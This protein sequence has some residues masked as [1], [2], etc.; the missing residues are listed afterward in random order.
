MMENAKPAFPSFPPRGG[1][2][3][4][5]IRI[6]INPFGSIE[7]MGDGRPSLTIESDQRVMTKVP[8]LYPPW[9]FTRCS[10]TGP[11]IPALDKTFDLI[12][13]HPSRGWGFVVQ[14][15]RGLRKLDRSRLEAQAR[16]CNGLQNCHF[17]VMLASFSPS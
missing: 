11:V 14:G 4:F 2:W 8:A 5:A 3:M 17:R 15:L 1:G 6:M 10:N 7:S 13:G 9:P 12:E 16:N